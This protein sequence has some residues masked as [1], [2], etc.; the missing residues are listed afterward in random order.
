MRLQILTIVIFEVK[1]PTDSP[2][3]A[4]AA[5]EFNKRKL[6]RNKSVKR[7]KVTNTNASPLHHTTT[8]TTSTNKSFNGSPISKNLMQSTQL[9]C[10]SESFDF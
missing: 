2:L 6:S 7:L 8:T 9:N 1:L 3:L 4:K 10:A 5:N